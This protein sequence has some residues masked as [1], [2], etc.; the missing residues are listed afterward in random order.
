MHSDT[1]IGHQILD[2]FTKRL[3]VYWGHDRKVHI[4]PCNS[5]A[6]S[7]LQWCRYIAKFSLAVWKCNVSSFFYSCFNNTHLEFFMRIKILFYIYWKSLKN[8]FFWQRYRITNPPENSKIGMILEFWGLFK[9]MLR[10]SWIEI[11]FTPFYISSKNINDL[12]GPNRC[13]D[14]HWRC[15]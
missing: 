6:R 13:F 15:W 3:Y 12:S 10:K 1:S 4:I 14:F 5:C 11:F 9:V 7:T 2:S 8:P